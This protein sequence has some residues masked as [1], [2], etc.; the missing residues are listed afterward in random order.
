MLVQTALFILIREAYLDNARQQ[1]NES[2]Q[3]TEGVFRDALKHRTLLLQD[4]ARLLSGDYAFK[5]TFASRDRAT[6]LSVL[7][8]HRH[9][10]GADVM[11]LL[12]FDS[13]SVL[14]NTLDP[15]FTQPQFVFPDLIEQAYNSE[16]GE[17]TA[18]RL[19]DGR[20]YQLVIV[21][22]FTPQPNAWIVIGFTLDDA[23]VQQLQEATRT[24]ISILAAPAQM[25]LQLQASTLPAPLRQALLSALEGSSVQETLWLLDEAYVSL[26]V[27]VTDTPA[28]RV[29]AVLQRPLKQALAAYLRV[30]HA[31]MGVFL[32]GV[33]LTLMG[34]FVLARSVSRPVQ[35]LLAGAGRIEQG[36]FQTRVRVRQQDELGLLAEAFNRMMQGLEER[37][38]ARDLLGKVVSPA[39]A[40]ELL[41]KKIELGGEER[42]VTV[43]FCDVRNFTSLC[44]GKSPKA[45]LDLLNRYFT[46]V[47]RLV[48]DH[49]GVIDKYIGD[50]VMALFGA[51]VRTACDARNAVV[52]AL[53]MIQALERFNQHLAAA[54]EPPIG[55]GVGINSDRV[56]AGNMGS[57][58]R[59]N[60]TVIG[61]GVN[62]A[63]RLEGLTKQYGVA[64]IVSEHTRQQC[65]DLVFCELDRVR[66]KGKQEPVE[67]YT[68]LGWR[69]SW[70][71]ER[72]AEQARYREALALYRTGRW[73]E[74][75]A[76]FEVLHCRQPGTRLYGVYLERCR[77]FI[78]EPPP[79][80]W[81]GVYTFTSK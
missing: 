16:T 74:A 72:E 5:K 63:S 39:I 68:P 33:V 12:T 40:E 25:P 10:A 47:S 14:A 8:N 9:R 15:A 66:V 79:P 17:V 75:A 50:A 43:L 13:A 46:E 30:Q 78:A 44:E 35:Q 62:L 19:M 64:V 28:L 56:V 54:G 20:A 21:P 69:S 77:H 31:F 70:G 11:M 32:G 81:D 51:P 24:E 18:I 42:E 3:L 60:Y 55:I 48:E 2:L 73:S 61:D 45:I 49:D 58:R 37:R 4:K 76:V 38:Q 53:E 57:T 67:I 22:L 71:G 1:I 7:E 23:I 27:R 80:D 29:S 65:H 34:A 52:T 6:I 36:D 26:E 41:G 59:L